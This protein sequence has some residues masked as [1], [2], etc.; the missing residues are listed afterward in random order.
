M[1][2]LT[3]GNVQV[4]AIEFLR[5]PPPAVAQMLVETKIQKAVLAEATRKAADA[6]PPQLSWVRENE[7]AFHGRDGV[8]ALPGRGQGPARA[9]K[10]HASDGDT[11]KADGADDPASSRC[12]R[13]GHQ[14]AGAVGSPWLRVASV[15]PLGHRQR[16][17]GGCGHQRRCSGGRAQLSG[18]RHNDRRHT[19]TVRAGTWAPD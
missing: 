15:A 17:G 14:A 19:S 10:A 7:S 4:A 2:L 1:L 11:G 13:A 9:A 12:V 18:Y 8:G 16:P 5:M 3:S 6:A